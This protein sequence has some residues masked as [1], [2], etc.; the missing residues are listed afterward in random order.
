MEAIKFTA[1]LDL[2]RHQRAALS[3]TCNTPGF[4]V[5]QLIFEEEVQKF[6][7]AL[8]NIE[9]GT[10]KVLEGQRVAKTAAQLWQGG[11][12]RINDEVNYLREELRGERPEAPVDLV[13][14]MI[15]LGPDASTQSSFEEGDEIEY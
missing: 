1:P 13:A 4:K 14:G 10:I 8:M 7:A 15:D 5:I 9:S 12:D 2:Q 11:I 3:D 6:Y